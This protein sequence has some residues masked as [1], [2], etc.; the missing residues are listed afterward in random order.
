MCWNLISIKLQA[1]L[2][3]MNIANFFRTPILKNICDRLLL[4][5]GRL[6]EKLIFEARRCTSLHKYKN[7]L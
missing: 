6:D 5:Q 1:G 3:A 2:Q 7:E 4:L